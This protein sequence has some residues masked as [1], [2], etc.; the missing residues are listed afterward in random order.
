MTHHIQ[1]LKCFISNCV[2]G[3]EDGT[4]QKSIQGFKSDSND[5]QDTVERDVCQEFNKIAFK[6]VGMKRAIFLNI[7]PYTICDCEYASI[8]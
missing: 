4:P 6:I 8:N 1:I 7:S 5:G 3:F 2:N